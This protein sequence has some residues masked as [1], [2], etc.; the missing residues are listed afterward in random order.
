M[1]DDGAIGRI[2][3]IRSRE[4]HSGPHAAHFWDADLTGGGA[5]MDMGCHMFE[6]FRYFLIERGESLLVAHDAPLLRQAPEPPPASAPAPA[7]ARK[8]KRR[9]AG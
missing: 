4:A 8:R 6:A 5:L 3:T 7:P 2:F 1:I 9:I